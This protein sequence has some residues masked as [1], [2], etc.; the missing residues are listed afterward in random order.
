MNEIEY[1]SKLETA[2]DKSLEKPGDSM[3]NGQV[4]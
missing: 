3:W 2:I 4:F 1:C